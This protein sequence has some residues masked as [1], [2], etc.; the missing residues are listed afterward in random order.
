MAVDAMLAKADVWTV[1]AGLGV[2]MEALSV[3]ADAPGFYH[4]GR[5]GV[6]R[7]G[8]KVVLAHF[9]ELH[10]RVLGELGL[11]GAAVAFEVFLDAIQE[12]KRRKKSAPE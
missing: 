4:P 6:V 8:P 9:G 5:S 2:P 7:Q 12:P 10:P 3:T 1:L 11:G